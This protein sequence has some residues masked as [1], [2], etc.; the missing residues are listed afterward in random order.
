VT[1]EQVL[2]GALG[3][4]PLALALGLAVRILWARLMERDAELDRIRKQQEEFLAAMLAA[5]KDDHS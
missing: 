4:S 1:W 3:S 5:C 2:A